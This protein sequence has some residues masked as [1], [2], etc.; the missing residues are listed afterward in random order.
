MAKA[1]GPDY[2]AV[3]ECWPFFNFSHISPVEHIFARCIVFPKSFM[4]IYY[5][6]FLL[7]M[8]FTLSKYLEIQNSYLNTS[9]P[10]ICRSKDTDKKNVSNIC[11]I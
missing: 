5:Y 3:S 4:N 2:E 11:F 7:C 8:E 9:F 6:Y 1:F 10:Q